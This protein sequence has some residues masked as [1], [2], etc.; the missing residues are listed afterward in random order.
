MILHRDGIEVERADATKTGLHES[1][2][3]SAAT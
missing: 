2:V 1:Q 3:K